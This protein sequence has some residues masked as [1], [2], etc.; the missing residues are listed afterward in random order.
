VHWSDIKPIL[1]D[2]ELYSSL[3]V[4]LYVILVGLVFAIAWLRDRARG[5]ARSVSQRLAESAAVSLIPGLLL[6]LLIAAAQIA[7][8]A[9][10]FPELASWLRLP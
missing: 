8:I 9:Q 4:N 5:A 7:T 3:V 1:I 10:A 6:V 2:V